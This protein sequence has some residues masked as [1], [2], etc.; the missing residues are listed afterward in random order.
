MSQATVFND[1]SCR[2]ELLVSKRFRIYR[3]LGLWI[4]MVLVFCSANDSPFDTQPYS[5][6]FKIGYSLLLILFSYINM[7]WLVPRF[8]LKNLFPQY[9]LGIFVF[10]VI[11]VVTI[12]I[13]GNFLEEYSATLNG[14][15]IKFIP[16]PLPSTIIALVFI[17]ASTAIK[18]FQ[19]WIEDSKRI[20]ELTKMGMQ[21]ELEQLKTQINP[22][23]LFN[24]LNNAN[25]LTQK[26]PAKAS[27]VLM[28][29]SDL[30]RYQLYD[31]AQNTVLL[32]SDIHFL[33]DFLN[34]EKIRRDQFDFM[35]SKEGPI[36]GIQIPP[37][38]FITFVENAIK[39]S[40]DMDHASFVN[41]FFEVR[42]KQLH[43]VCI[44]SK[45]AQSYQKNDVGGL[46]LINVKRRLA[47]LFGDKHDLRIEDGKELY[48]VNLSIEL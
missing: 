15:S 27:Q 31:S 14:G 44:N 8:L 3:H 7:Y 1:A 10:V 45:P 26:D 47:L 25:V 36:S 24:M 23:F 33:N 17:A 13:F 4:I 37:F 12:I 5:V 41:L 9:M 22:H 35:V 48:T 16:K 38:L 6:H 28:T 46:G 18:L 42:N 32:T 21:S 40:L 19:R 20:S 34:L 29:L 2:V 39:H 11:S 30:L 43:F